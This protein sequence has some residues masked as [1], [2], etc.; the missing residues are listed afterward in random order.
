MLKIYIESTCIIEVEVRI[1]TMI[2]VIIIII[3]NYQFRVARGKAMLRKIDK[4]E[5]KMYMT[6]S[7]NES[8]V[9]VA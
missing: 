3:V 2:I 4:P 6:F 7:E 1:T 5:A 8:K 9:E